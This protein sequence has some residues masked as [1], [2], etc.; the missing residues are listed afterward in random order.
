MISEFMVVGV[1]IC[2]Q[3][4]RYSAKGSYQTAIVKKW[5]AAVSS[6]AAVMWDRAPSKSIFRAEYIFRLPD[7]RKRDLDN[8]AKA[9]SDALNGIIWDDDCQIHDLHLVK[10]YTTRDTIAGVRINVEEI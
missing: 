5:Q 2:K 8:L 7:K 10:V 1:P 3:S 9:V 4:F 6:A